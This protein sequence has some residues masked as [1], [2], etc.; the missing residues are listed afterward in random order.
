M[1]WHVTWPPQEKTSSTK[2]GPWVWKFGRNCGSWI[3]YFIYSGCCGAIWR[4]LHFRMYPCCCISLCHVLWYIYVWASNV[5]GSWPATTTFKSSS[6]S[7]SFVWIPL[8]DI[9]STKKQDVDIFNS[10]LRKPTNPPPAIIRS[11]TFG[12]SAG[13]VR[14]YHCACWRSS[15]RLQRMCKGY[16]SATQGRYIPSRK[17]SRWGYAR[18]MWTSIFFVKDLAAGV[19]CWH[20]MMQKSMVLGCFTIPPFESHGLDGAY[21]PCK[22]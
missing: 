12:T 9:F 8:G 5:E 4:H 18:G 17:L 1:A 14:M 21:H 19:F 11:E 22:I 15:L 16:P 10:P 20:Q 13:R 3:G 2:N 7:V 6:H